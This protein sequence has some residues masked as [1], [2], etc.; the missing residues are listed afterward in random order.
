MKKDEAEERIVADFLALPPTERQT[1]TQAACFAIRVNGRY[2][3]S[4]KDD[5]VRQIREWLQPHVGQAI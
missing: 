2:R 5:P 3:F 1:E 4:S